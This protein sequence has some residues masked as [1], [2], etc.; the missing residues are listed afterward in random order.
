MG[1][2]WRAGSWSDRARA[3][4][5]CRLFQE[6]QYCSRM[7]ANSPRDAALRSVPARR[8]RRLLVMERGQYIFRRLREVYALRG[9][10]RRET[11]GPADKNGKS[12]KTKN[13]A[14]Q[15]GRGRL[16][17]CRLELASAAPMG[18]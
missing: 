15:A 10:A 4:W 16:G 17:T 18:Q 7:A 5:L 11:G 1:L 9:A 6:T 13:P 14:G 8:A 3:G 12:M 2:T